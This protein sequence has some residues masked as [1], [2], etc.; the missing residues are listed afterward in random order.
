MA[1][2]HVALGGYAPR[3]TAPNAGTRAGALLPNTV[4][5]MRSANM[6][7]A[8]QAP[9][10]DMGHRSGGRCHRHRMGQR[11]TRCFCGGRMVKSSRCRS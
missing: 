2:G 6:G 4:P 8:P 11:G 5:L 10:A 1:N 9:K 3:S 7:I